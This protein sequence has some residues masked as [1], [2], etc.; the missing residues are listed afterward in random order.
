VATTTTTDFDPYRDWGV[1]AVTTQVLY[2][3]SQLAAEEW[4]EDRPHLT[5]VS[6]PQ[7]GDWEPLHKHQDLVEL[8]DLTDE[9]LTALQFQVAHAL[10]RRQGRQL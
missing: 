3:G 9:Q 5:V 2:S 8:D 10:A 6:R 1:F 4:T 7:D